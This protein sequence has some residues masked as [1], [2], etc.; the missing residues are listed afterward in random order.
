MNFW[1]TFW[2]SMLSWAVGFGILFFVIIVMFVS[3]IISIIPEIEESSATGNIL[4]I[5]LNENIVDAPAVSI[6]SGLDATSLTVSET[7]TTLQVLAAIDNAATD[8]TIDGICIN[9]EGSGVISMANTEELREA[10]ERFKL[11]GKFIVAYD[12]SYT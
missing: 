12:D 10:L 5:N 7:L 8:D 2:A 3:M 6:M 1:K 4:C 11:S 9:T